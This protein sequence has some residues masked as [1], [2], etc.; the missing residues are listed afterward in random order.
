MPRLIVLM[1]LTLYCLFNA[2]FGR[3]LSFVLIGGWIVIVSV[4]VN[5]APLAFL[6]VTLKLYTPAVFGVPAMRTR[7]FDNGHGQS[8]RQ[9][10]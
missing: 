7:R 8:R 10:R 3:A 9:M 6:M 2:N 4:L 5:V 1:R